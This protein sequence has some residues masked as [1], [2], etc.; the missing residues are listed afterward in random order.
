MNSISIKPI[1]V[2]MSTYNDQ[3]YITESINSILNQSF[4]NFNFLIVDDCSTDKTVE[5]IKSF[6]DSR[7][8]LIEN[9]H[10]L[11]LT[12][13]LIKAFDFAKSKYIAR[14]DA[15]DIS[16]PKRLENQYEFMEKN[17]S[18]GI[19]GCWFKAFGSVNEKIVKY[20]THHDNIAMKLLYQTQICHA[21][22]FI[23]REV[24]TQ[25]NIN[26]DPKF[27][28]AQDYELW[29]R[30]Q[31]VTK[32]ANLPEVLFAVR[33]HNKSISIKKKNQQWANHISIMKNQFKRIGLDLEEID[34]SHFLR[35]CNGYHNFKLEE[36]GGLSLLLERIININRNSGYY[37]RRVL[38]NFI[39]GRWFHL[40]Y[41][42]GSEET[43]YSLSI[44]KNV[45]FINRIKFKIKS[46]LK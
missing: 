38:E 13:N 23:R 44:S 11:G 4:K 2:I 17:P 22:S 28:T 27:I 16:Y 10:N 19:C 24:L 15:D 18:I 21:A 42:C 34:I 1:T 6:N 9:K 30:L 37:K 45:G 36:L 26:Y 29:T 25:N 43:F 8:I 35:F 12:K 46:Y 39:S 32:I 7:I 14:M 41:N 3:D 40:N 33:Y 5:K 20:E 31:V